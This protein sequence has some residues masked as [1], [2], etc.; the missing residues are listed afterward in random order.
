MYLAYWGLQ[1]YPF[2]NVPD[3]EFMYYS[4]EHEEALA[5]YRWL[6]SRL[7]EAACKGEPPSANRLAL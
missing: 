3:P 1:K 2:E 5:R 6:A 7:V 4:S